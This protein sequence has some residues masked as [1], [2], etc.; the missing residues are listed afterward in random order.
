MAD[1]RQVV[2]D[3]ARENGWSEVAIH[4]VFVFDRGVWRVQMCFTSN[5]SIRDAFLQDMRWFNPD[6]RGGM[7]PLRGRDAVLKTLRAAP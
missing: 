3:C 4:D 1:S 6:R 7:T 2:R 5:G